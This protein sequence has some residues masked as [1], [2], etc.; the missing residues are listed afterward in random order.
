MVGEL[1]DQKGTL[2]AGESAGSWAPQLVG[3]KAEWKVDETVE[4]RG[5]EK[6]VHLAC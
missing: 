4:K 5:D 2:W 1:V 6:A 3:E